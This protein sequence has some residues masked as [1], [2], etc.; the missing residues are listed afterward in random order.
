MARVMGLAVEDRA[1]TRRSFRFHGGVG[2]QD[3]D[4]P[5]LSIDRMRALQLDPLR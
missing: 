5:L 4:E 2:A 1:S 3:S